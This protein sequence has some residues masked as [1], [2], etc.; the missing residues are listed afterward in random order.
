MTSASA[1]TTATLDVYSAAAL[2]AADPSIPFPVRA[3]EASRLSITTHTLLQSALAAAVSSSTNA[4]LADAEATSDPD[5]QAR[6]L[7]LRLQA[8]QDASDAILAQ[9][10]YASSLA[11]SLSLASG[12]VPSPEIA[13]AIAVQIT[14]H[15]TATAALLANHAAAVAAQTAVS[16]ASAANAVVAALPGNNVALGDDT[17]SATFT[18][19]TIRDFMKVSAPLAENVTLTAAGI[20]QFVLLVPSA[21]TITATAAAATSCLIYA[22]I[23][24]ENMSSCISFDCHYLL[25]IL[26]LSTWIQNIFRPKHSQNQQF[27]ENPVSETW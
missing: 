12:V 14:A 15:A 27:C 25:I 8:V 13:T 2:N 23:G 21:V 24:T 5:S 1:S 7:V 18:N 3:Q 11:A 19:P 22:P 9:A 10:L 20:F 4:D 16:A 17:G 26:E 6:A